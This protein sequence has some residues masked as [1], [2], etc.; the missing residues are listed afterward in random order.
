VAVK[1]SSSGDGTT[2][3]PRTNLFVKGSALR[4]GCSAGLELSPRTPLLIRV[5]QSAESVRWMHVQ[6]LA[7]VPSVRTR[8][9]FPTGTTSANAG[10]KAS[11]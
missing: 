8:T 2:K 7:L 10:A 9:M 5:S 11:A 4:R 3:A 6:K 1:K